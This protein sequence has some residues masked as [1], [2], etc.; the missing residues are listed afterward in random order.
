MDGQTA[1]WRE[2]GKSGTDK[3]KPGKLLE[4]SNTEVS[5]D[6]ILADREGL[7]KADTQSPEAKKEGED[8]VGSIQKEMKTYPFIDLD[9]IQRQQMAA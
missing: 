4:K 5:L 7:L 6:P 2:G 9:K 1:G 3:P 8:T